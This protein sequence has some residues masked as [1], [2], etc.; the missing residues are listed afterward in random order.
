MRDYYP[1]TDVAAVSW[2][3]H[4]GYDVSYLADPDVDRDPTQLQDHA[5]VVSGV[6]DEYWTQGIRDAFTAARDHGTSL[7]FLGANASFWRARYDAG[8]DRRTLVEYKTTQGGEAD[9]GGPTA[10][11]RD[12]SGP[13]HPENALVGQ[14]YAGDNASSAWGLKVSGAQGRN[15]IWRHT[16][17]GD[18]DPTATTTLGTGL[19]GWE[20][21]TRVANGQEPAGV[22]T[23]ASTP[24]DGG[25]AQ[26]SGAVNVP[27][28]T[29]Q[30]TTLY[31]APSGAIVFDTGTNFW[32]RGLAPNVD[33][34]EDA[35]GR[36]R[37]ATANVLA[38]MGAVATTPDPALTF[39]APGAPHVTGG[40]PANGATGVAP[41]AAITATFDR[42]LDPSTVDGDS[43]TLSTGGTPVATTVAWDRATQTITVTPTAPLAASA[44]TTLTLGT[45][46]KTWAGTALAAAVTR[47]FTP[48]A[49]P[50]PTL[51]STTPADGATG[52]PIDVADI[53]ATASQA[54][55]AATVTPTTVT[56]RAGSAA[57]IDSHV[58]YNAS[59]RTIALHPGDTLAQGT[60]YTMTLSGVHA[61][62][63]AALATTSWTF[64]TSANLTVSAQSP[65]A[66][67]TGVSPS[68]DVRVTFSRAID[69]T[70]LTAA[71]LFLDDADGAP[72]AAQL[73]YDATTRTATLTPS[74]PLALLSNYR[75]TVAAGIRAADGAPLDPTLWWFSTAPAAPTAP[76]VTALLPAADAGDAFNGTAVKATFDRDLD[77]AT[78]G[79]QSFTLTTAAGTPVAATVGYDA[80]KRQ[81]VLRPL[82]QLATDATYTATLT[83][84]VSSASGTPLGAPVTWS[85]TTARCPCSLL[86]GQT[87]AETG[88]SGTFELGVRVTSQ[89]ASSLVAVK[90]YKSPGETGTH[91][92]R[93]WDAAGQLLGQATFASETASGWQRQALATAIPL[94]AGQVYTVSVNA[95]SKWVKTGWSMRDPISSGPLSSLADDLN[96][97]YNDAPGLFPASSYQ[98]TNYF[99][100]PVIRVASAPARVPQVSSIT[101]TSGATGVSA[102]APVRVAFTQ[103]LDDSTID[104]SS[105][106]LT[107][108]GN[109]NVPAALAYDDD[110]RTV[111]LSPSSPLTP[112]G[113]YTLRLSTGLRSDDDTPLAAAVT[114][115][116]AVASAAIGPAVAS[117]SPAQGATGVAGAVAP[118][119]T[120]DQA[121]DPSTLTGAT[122][123]LTAPGGATVPVTTAVSG[124]TRT[125]TATPTATLNASTAYTLHVSTGA[126]SALGAALG[127]AYNLTFTTGTGCPCRLWGSNPSPQATTLDVA[128][129]RSGGSPYS[130]ELGVKFRVD[131]AASLTAVRFYKDP[132]ETDGHTAHLWTSDGTLVASV[133]FGTESNQGWQRSG[134]AVPVGLTAGQTYILSVGVNSKFGMSANSPLGTGLSDGPLSAVVD[135]ANGVFADA[136]GTF[137]TQ[138]WANSNYF[139]DPEVQ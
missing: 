82:A 87:P 41:T 68:A 7:V 93:V 123:T 89:V 134:L 74:A 20:W 9:P 46:L 19:V 117:T 77:G 62:G 84:A 100:D 90:F 8:S 136:A 11:W 114:S 33:G 18:Q 109:A 60:T 22:K 24:V 25:I 30:M 75:V 115:S 26:G 44:T 27:G 118:S 113:A 67:A 70:T 56:L 85:F 110:T 105:V 55:D 71:R 104:A 59:T 124:D 83:T 23:L 138:S 34:T 106:R 58:D 14:M 135:N 4:Q 40:V 108:A 81:A 45:G 96:G 52:V 98:W 21:D 50:P 122:V 53:T 94:A 31:K 54:L 120:F 17:L 92:G 1:R 95:N 126:K 131:R 80:T 102:T 69:A 47:S 35:N 99:I 91:V 121:M 129:G 64:T 127:S 5:I 97:V 28:A 72:V 16:T 57:P 133:S 48:G 43:V 39:D 63:G 137:P 73:S 125:V 42:E 49:G 2:L 139:I 10:T 66:L 38:D 103:P 112:G 51:T 132:S 101:P 65:A 61:D 86:S 32:A 88:L 76:A 130:L 37:Q 119:V 3:E 78:V 36:I 29:T 12:P 79:G 128:N 6:H 15:R 111:T 107:D 13:N 116:F